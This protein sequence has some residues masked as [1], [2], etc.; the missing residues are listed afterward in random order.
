MVHVQTQPVLMSA[1][2]VATYCGVDIRTVRRWIEG[3]WD[4]QPVRSPTGR[5]LFHRS[6]VVAWFTTDGIGR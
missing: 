1:G 5:I 3:G 2:D 4:V 6:D